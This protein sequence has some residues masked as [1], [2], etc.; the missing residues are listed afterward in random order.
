MNSMNGDGCSTQC[1]K[2]PFFNCIGESREAG[3]CNGHACSF[4]IFLRLKKE[5]KKNPLMQL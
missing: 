2:E 5:Q 4:A 3:H 1:Q